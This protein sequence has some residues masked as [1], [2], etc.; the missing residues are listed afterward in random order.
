MMPITLILIWVRPPIMR[1]INTYATGG[2][3]D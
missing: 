2:D 1:L 3:A